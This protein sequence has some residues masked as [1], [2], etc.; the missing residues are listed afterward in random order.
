MGDEEDL[1]KRMAL[2]TVQFKS[3]EK[4]WGRLKSLILCTDERV[5]YFHLACYSLSCG[6]VHGE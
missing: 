5:Q 2:A 1:V 4:V 6:R 3:P